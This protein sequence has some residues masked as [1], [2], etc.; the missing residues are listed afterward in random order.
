MRLNKFI[1]ECGIS[2][3][4]KAEELIL[5]GRITINNKTV[6]QLSYD[7]NP[8]V[9]EVFYDGERLKIENH[10]Y[11]LLNKP[12]GVVTTTDDEKKRLA[13]T[14]LI[15]TNLKIFPVGR[16]DFNTTGV[17]I[18][19][20]DGEFANKLIHPRN[21]II[22]EY[23]VRLDRELEYKDEQLL[24]TGVFIDNKR[25]K[26]TSIEFKKKK[27]RKTL[28]VKC[29]EGRNHFVKKMF[30]MLSYTVERLHRKSFAGITDDIPVG[31]YRKLTK[32]EIQKL[33]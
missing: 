8:D 22:R 2:S 1:A 23:E 5:Q 9:D 12:K 10:V 14:D 27:D 26:F 6:T 19:T 20:N 18:L 24:L 11:Y 16:L 4:R 33:S 15:K 28:T 7:V 17:L 29:T 31:S 30:G 32:D 3:R 13:V 25:G 21:N